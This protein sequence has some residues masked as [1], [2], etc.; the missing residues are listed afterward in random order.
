[1]ARIVPFAGA[2]DDAHVIVFPGIGRVRQIFER[3][4]EINV[5]IMVTV[6]KRTYIE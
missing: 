6:E 3:A 5:V 2:D 1:M 4:V